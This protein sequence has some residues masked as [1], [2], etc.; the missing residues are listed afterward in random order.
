MTDTEKLIREV[1]LPRI[2]QLE[3]EVTSLRKYTWP[4]V[5]A[6]REYN[7]MDDIE[8]KKDFVKSLDDDTIKELL[9]LKAKFSETSGLQK[10]EY[11]ALKNHFC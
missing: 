10:S 5:Q 11:E 9:N 4:Y 3:I 7:Q 6:Q 2:I 8:A 1:L